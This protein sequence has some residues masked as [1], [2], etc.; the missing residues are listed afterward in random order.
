MN[1]FPSP[2]YNEKVRWCRKLLLLRDRGFAEAKYYWP[3]FFFGC[4]SGTRQPAIMDLL[5]PH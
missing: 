1:I 2:K 4:S 3:F 5:I